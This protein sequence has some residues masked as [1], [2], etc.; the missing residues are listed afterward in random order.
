MTP[1]PNENS[2]DQDACRAVLGEI[3]ERIRSAQYAALRAVN[4]ELLSQDWDIGRLIGLRQRRETRF[5]YENVYFSC[6]CR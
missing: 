6:D 1:V 2:L 5:P 3:M 4:L